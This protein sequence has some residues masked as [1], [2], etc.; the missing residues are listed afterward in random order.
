MNSKTIA[1]GILRAILIIVGVVLILYFLYQIRAILVYI[2]LDSVISLI[3]R[4]IVIFF[5]VKLK[6]P[7]TLAAIIT[8]GFFVGI[9]TLLI[10]L[11]VPLLVE[12]SHNLSKIDIDELEVEINQL[13]G[14]IDLYFS[15]RGIHLLA[16][17]Q[18]I[19]FEEL[20]NL[21]SVTTI[22]SSV[23]GF[24]GSFS[25]G[26]LA[27]LFISFFMLKDGAILDNIIFTLV[28]NKQESKARKSWGTIKDLLSR[29]FT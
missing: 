20:F 28:P 5:D 11:L 25:I 15:D 9:L 8:M 13:L 27:T 29:Y 22:F 1:N 23:I 18:N 17:L 4:R 7:N 6:L 3:G 24:I 26:L 19:S 2:A 10:S 16:K 21:G 14:D 12:Q